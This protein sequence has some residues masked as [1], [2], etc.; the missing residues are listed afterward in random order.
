VEFSVK[1]VQVAVKIMNVWGLN[2]LNE[3]FKA[4]L[5]VCSRWK[6]PE[7]QKKAVIGSLRADGR[8]RDSGWVPDWAPKFSVWGCVEQQN[9]MREYE[10]YREDPGDPNKPG[11]TKLGA[12]NTSNVWVEGMEWFTVVVTKV[13]ELQNFPFDVQDL[14]IHLSLDNAERMALPT[15]DWVSQAPD[16]KLRPMVRYVKFMI[17]NFKLRRLIFRAPD[18]PGGSR[19]SQR[20]KT[21]EDQWRNGKTIGDYS[22]QWKTNDD[23]DQSSFLHV[24]VLLERQH[25]FYSSHGVWT[26]IDLV[27]PLHVLFFH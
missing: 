8:Q 23:D 14:D 4:E 6:V 10:A 3:C 5:R 25:R 18:T 16:G 1:E 27:I 20:A 2:A 19:A 17:Q 7:A 15:P 21:K 22:G 26:V 24:V 9:G 11:F 12:P 13:F